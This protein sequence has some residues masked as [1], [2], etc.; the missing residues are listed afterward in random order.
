MSEK[1][2]PEEVSNII[3]PLFEECNQA[4][5]RF[6]GVI[7]KFIGDALMALFGVPYAHEDDPERAALAAL[8]MRTIIQRFGADLEQR[9]GFSINM[10]IGLNVGTVVAGSVDGPNGKNYQVLG[11]AINTAARM[12]QNAEPGHVLVTEEMYRLLRDSFELRA[13]KLITAKGKKQPLQAY[14]LVNIRKHQQRRRGFENRSIHFIGRNQELSDLS[15]WVRQAFEENQ[16]SFVLLSG[17][18]GLGKTRL[19]Q[20]TWHQVVSQGQPLKMLQGASTSYSRDFP[21]FMLQS[22]IRSS[23]DADNNLEMQAVR[24]RLQ[25]HLE[26]LNLP[27]R[28]LTE[29]LLEYVLFPQLEKPQLKLMSP[30]R[31]QQ[32]IFKAAADFLLTQAKAQPLFIQIDDLQWCDSLSLHWL[33]YMRQNL[34]T[35]K[36]PIIFCITCR[37]QPSLTDFSN[38]SLDW[39]GHSQL[40]A[41]NPEECRQLICAVLELDSLPDT[42]KPLAEAVLER[43]SGN[44]YYIEEVFKI[45]L[46]DQLLVLEEQEWKL[47]SPLHEL[48]LPSSIQRLVMSRFDRL[49]DEQR[50]LMQTLSVVGR[51]TPMHLLERLTDQN[52]QQVLPALKSLEQAGFIWLTQTQEP[53]IVF[54]QALTQEVIYSTLVNRRQRALHQEI[55]MA[56]EELHAQNLQSVLDLLAFH[57]ARTP[58]TAKAIRYLW[59][60]A[61]QAARLYA[62]EQALSQLEQIQNLLTQLDAQA[63]IAMDLKS[64]QWM[65]K[66]QVSR[67]ALLLRSD[68]LLLTGAYDDL[69]ELVEKTLSEDPPLQ[70]KARML[71]LRGRVS[72]K[73]SDFALAKQLFEEACQYYLELADLS[74]Q[75]RMWNAIGW[76]SRWM[77]DYSFAQSACEQALKLLEQQPDMEQIA[78]AHNVMGVAL[79]SLHEWEKALDHYRQSLEIQTQIQDLWGRANS[80]SNMGNVYFMINRWN[81]AVEVFEQSLSIRE[82][83]GD[84]EG[85]SHSYNNLG[86]AYQA[87]GR[88]EEAERA[89]HQALGRYRQLG[90][91][92]GVA[93][94]QCNLASLHFRRHEWEQALEL[95]QAGISSI[96]A[97][98]MDAMLPEAL[99]H[100]IE[101]CLKLQRPA[102]THEYLE[103]DS[104]CV[105]T[106][107]DPIQKGRLERL[108][109]QYYL[110]QQE[111]EQ[112]LA[113]FKKAVDI[114][115][116]TDHR[117]E[118]Q[119]L[120][121]QLA[122]LQRLRGSDE[123]SYWEDLCQSLQEA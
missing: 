37:T 58:E 106:H 68:I 104:E 47:N 81:E 64:R 83:L 17:E 23:I 112:A 18:S 114:L 59:L 53:E 51:M 38:S 16:P 65:R 34:Q 26:E 46:E 32:Q 97:R 50:L 54:Q 55:A 91:I 72:E 87:L 92:L 20:E 3:Q 113:C 60:S 120:Y 6:G 86:H 109:G 101:I 105:R 119:M 40:H 12:E 24:E 89:L 52:Q 44:P 73:R 103:S 70:L 108:W 90:N 41:L 88:L 116:P 27:G 5:S 115:Q 100:R 77:G 80:L 121:Q 21:Y 4:I 45:L 78:Y 10:R 63:L 28:E 110:T 56:L 74:G 85:T 93:V 7:E 39:S 15:V 9:M 107:G 79:F 82:Q 75:A 25:Q 19:A 122:E 33:V 99:N 2:D 57:Y 96:Q 29:N 67:E 98:Q 111:P 118:C 71:Y 22:L 117:E 61:E 95:L 35:R 30:E 49:P 84:L 76:V 94:V 13:D 1:L 31:L 36:L 8:E 69:L 14:E 43:A 42:L 11:D 62:N 102:A 123:A 66:D 48:P